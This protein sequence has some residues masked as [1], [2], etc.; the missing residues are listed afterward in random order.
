MNFILRFIYAVMSLSPLLI[1]FILKNIESIKEAQ[2]INESW[3]CIA[4]CFV[5]VAIFACISYLCIRP[6]TNIN[7]QGHS[8]QC[9]EIEIAEPKYIPIYIAYF[10]IALSIPYDWI[11]F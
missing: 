11:I 1:I 8:M 6:Y 7:T 9:T 3:V 5:M 4:I 10:V 2:I